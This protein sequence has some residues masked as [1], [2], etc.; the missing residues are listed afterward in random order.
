VIEQRPQTA[1][2]GVAIASAVNVVSRILTFLRQVLITAY[3]GLSARLDAFFVAAAFVSIFINTFGDIFDSAGIPSLVKSREREGEESFRAL[4]GSVFTLAV[5]LGVGMSLMMILCLPLAPLL[6]PG[7]PQASKDFIRGNVLLLLPYALAYLPYHAIGSFFRSVRGFHIYYLVECVV[8]LVALAVVIGFADTVLVVPVSLSAAYA[9][10]IVAF[11]VWGR[12]RFRFRGRLSGGEMDVVRRTVGQMLPV[13]VI[14][15]GLIVVD[16]YFGSFL[17]EGAI[18]ALFYGYVLAMAVPAV[19]NIENVFITPLSEESDRG[20]LMTRILSGILVVAL[21][22]LAFAFLFGG[23]LVKGLFE[24]GAFTERSSLMT[25]EAL[26]FYIL[27]LPA[28]FA[29]PVCIRTLQVLRR[30][31]WIAGLSAL[32]LLLNAGLNAL[33]VLG[34]GMGVRGIAL[35]TSLSYAAVGAAALALVSRAGIR[36]RYAETLRVLPNVACGVAVALGAAAVLP[37]PASPLAAILVRG[38]AFVAVYLP[39]A[40]LIPGPEM[41]RL[42]DIVLDS[43]PALRRAGERFR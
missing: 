41:R 39:V 10:G 20:V 37:V 29:L 12:T 23:A 27:G 24:R 19:M 38:A 22:V 4:T 26:R 42:R 3:F 6:V 25:A 9:V 34:A 28:F 16:R 11:V 31:G 13:Y 30:L 43:F 17:E 35:A 1:V 7:F 8:Q 18:S 33:F 40:V 15:Y 21:P 14:L 2:Q 32:S 5:L 36:V